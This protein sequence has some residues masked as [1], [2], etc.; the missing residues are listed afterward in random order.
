MCGVG[1]WVSQPPCTRARIFTS[2]NT[3][4]SPPTLV[5]SAMLP[6]SPTA[7]KSELLAARSRHI[8]ANV[9]L[10]YSRNPLVILKGREQH[11]YDEVR[12]GGSAVGSPWQGAPLAQCGARRCF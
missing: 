2:I 10:N 1:S 12:D 3:P 4:R 5:F 9:A 8:G 6:S 7:L 11:L